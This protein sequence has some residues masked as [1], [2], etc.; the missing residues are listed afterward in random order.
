MFTRENF[1]GFTLDPQQPSQPLHAQ[2]GDLIDLQ[3]LAF[4]VGARGSARWV[5]RLFGQ[6]QEIEVGHGQ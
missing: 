5:A 3:S 2:R 1:T 6:P 4:T